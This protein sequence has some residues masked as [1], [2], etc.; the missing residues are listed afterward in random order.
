MAGFTEGELTL[1]RNTAVTLKYEDIREELRF[2]RMKD[3]NE[4][5]IAFWEAVLELV[6][7]PQPKKD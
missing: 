5:D 4:E 2:A 3:D 7:K 1:I 6:K